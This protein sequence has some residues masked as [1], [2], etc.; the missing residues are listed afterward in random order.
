MTSDA[1]SSRVRFSVDTTKLP[2]RNDSF[3]YILIVYT[4]YVQVMPKK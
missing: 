2:C 4:I 3:N 1:G